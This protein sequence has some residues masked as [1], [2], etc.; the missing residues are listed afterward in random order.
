LENGANTVTLLHLFV[1]ALVQAITEFLPISSS[2]HLILLPRVLDWSD[3]GLLFD[4]AVH[5]GTLFAVIAYFYRD[6][7]MVIVGTGQLATGRSTPG[8]RLALQLLIATIPLLI[9]GLFIYEYVGDALR[10]VELIAW[11]T[12]GF[13][14]LLYLADKVGMTVNRL[15]HMNLPRALIIGV[16]QVLALIPGTS[17]AGIT[18]TAARF[19]G[20]ERAEA[21]RFS[22]LL[23]IPAILAAG[24]VAGMEVY[25]RGEMDFT[26][27]LLIAAGL[28]FV[29]A[30]IAIALMMAW[31][32]HATF[33]P[34]VFYRF[35]LGGAL[36]W[37]IYGG[38]AFFMG[39][40]S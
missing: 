35:A 30:L 24:T 19:L 8:S 33:T 14:A 5:V 7:G 15:E 3:Q 28:A 23:S 39:T 29:G 17:R 38:E 31:L 32:R 20:F 6:V 34:F 11:T 4:I 25:E 16:A 22:M 13:G 18:M 2:A 9:V 21:A 36:L 12:I 1:L 37:W 27:S 10:S 26:I 40:A